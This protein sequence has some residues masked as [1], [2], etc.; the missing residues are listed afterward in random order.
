MSVRRLLAVCR[1]DAF[2]LRLCFIITL[3]GSV[4]LL[5]GCDKLKEL[6]ALRAKARTAEVDE[7]AAF[8]TYRELLV[9]QGTNEVMDAFGKPQSIFETGKRTT[10]AFRRWRVVF[11]K[12]MKVV[13]MEREV[14]ASAGGI[15][16][17]GGRQ[18]N[19]L[20]AGEGMPRPVVRAPEPEPEPEP[21]TPAANIVRVTDG[22]AEVDL[23]ALVPPGK[24][25]IVDFYA[26]W[27]GPCKAIAPQ[28]E[29]LARS[30]PN[31]QLVKIDIVRWGTPVTR[32]YNIESVPNLRVFNPQRQQ[33]GS[34]T[35]DLNQVL[36]YLRQAGL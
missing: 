7:D 10:W 30:N 33:V 2:P 31:V 29:K 14:A 19:T 5:T 1:W 8:F 22:G 27:C 28:L 36:N 26:D 3:A 15:P 34:P 4:V 21:E 17:R 9:G 23:A 13:D 11:N 18:P 12:D 6:I 25:T 20:A 35:H 16:I 24:V 32:Q